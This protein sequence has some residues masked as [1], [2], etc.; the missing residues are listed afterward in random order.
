MTH[1]LLNIFGSTPIRGVATPYWAYG[2][3]LSLKSMQQN[4]I[5][6]RFIQHPTLACWP[7]NGDNSLCAAKWRSWTFCWIYS[8]MF[9]HTGAEMANMISVCFLEKN[10]ININGCRGQSYDNTTSLSGKYNGVQALIL[11]RCSVADYTPCWAH[12]LNLV[13]K[14]AAECCSATVESNFDILQGLYT[15]LAAYCWRKHRGKMYRLPEVLFK[16]W[17]SARYDDVSAINKR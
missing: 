2:S 6:F 17:W 16:T 10:G 13:C 15:W 8:Y 3:L 9:A 1:S 7:I 11:E 4:I 5:Q 12:S 14:S